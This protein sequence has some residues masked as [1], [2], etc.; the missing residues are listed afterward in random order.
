VA[1]L[2]LQDAQ[3]RLLTELEQERKYLAREIHDQVIQDLLGVNYHP[4]EIEAAGV[5]APALQEE[6]E[7]VRNG[8]R[9]L[10]DDLRH[11]CGSLRPP[12]IDSLGLGSALQSYTR[13]WSNRTG[14]PVTLDLDPNL[15]RLPETTELSIFRIVQEGLSNVRKHASAGSVE[16]CLKH[17][18]LRSLMVSI[19][20]DGRGLPEDFDFAALSAEGHYCLLGISERV[21]LLGGRSRF[22]NQ[23]EGGM[24]VQVEIP[25]PRVSQ[26]SGA[27]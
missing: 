10:V 17:T 15:G 14:T 27:T 20:D 21:A 24:L 26:P 5:T 7:S 19:S 2:A 23:P 3:R 4:E 13:Q 1:S 9:D 18:L 11:I 12:T 8:I 16:I 6:M 22:Q 25:Y